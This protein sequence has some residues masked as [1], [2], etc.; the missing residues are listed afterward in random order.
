[1]TT[2]AM[3]PPPCLPRVLDGSVLSQCKQRH[4]HQE[5]LSFLRHIEQAVP[6]DLEVHLILDNYGTHKHPR[7][8]AWLAA[9]PRWHVHFVPTYSS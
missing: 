8:K 6:R 9:R 5:F 3:A 7:V 4:R 2:G 1:M